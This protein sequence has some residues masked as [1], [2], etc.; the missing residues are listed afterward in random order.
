[1]RLWLAGARNALVAWAA[2]TLFAGVATQLLAAIFEIDAQ[3]GEPAAHWFGHPLYDPWR[4]LHWGV[5]LAPVRPGIAFLCVL[6]ALVF[7]LATF[8]TLALAGLI[9]P[10]ELPCFRLRRGFAAWDNLSQ[11]GLLRAN[12]LALG[13]AR[14]H[15]LAKPEIISAPAGNVALVGAP[16]HTDASLIAAIS[17]WRG[18]LVLI[19]ARGLAFRLP[20]QN[21][22]R[23]APG[24]ADSASYNPIL[25]I[26][27]GAHAWA[28]ALLLARSFLQS[29]DDAIIEAF[30]ILVLDQLLAASPEQRNLAA[31]RR[32]LSERH[33]VLAEI[34][35]AWPL[36][37]CSAP[38]PQCEIARAVQVWRGTPNAAV[39]RLSVIDAALNLCANGAYEQVT[40]AHQFR[41]ADL[42][43]GDGAD[44]CV[45]SLPQGDAASPAPLI[46][47]MLA[48]LV[49]ECAVQPDVDH[50]GRPKQR[51]L[52]LV[53][54][55][56]ALQA[57]EA[58]CTFSLLPAHSARNGCHLLA[59]APAIHGATREAL[60]AIAAIGPQ[61]EATSAHLSKLGGAV[62]CW[63]SVQTQ[64]PI[65]R[66]WAF[67]D[68]E[69][70]RRPIVSPDD[71]H[72][73]DPWAA[74]L[75]L[76]GMG[77]IL[78]RAV[79]ANNAQTGFANGATLDPVAHDWSAPAPARLDVLPPEAAT[80]AAAAP[81]GTKI[82]S[83]LTRRAPP[84][85]Q[86]KTQS[87]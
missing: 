42:V 37:F 65:W 2:M 66:N 13:A 76:K 71:L 62:V 5:E 8:A 19:E 53:V 49:M 36:K 68:W 21:V 52:L 63:R 79:C 59:Q 46:S 15:W 81:I 54:E 24:R 39:D 82:R 61:T 12:G 30:A 86:T 60:D 7:V 74:F 3:F 44:T 27:S 31:I 18:A 16:E 69:R 26:R 51:E 45:I 48:Q 41:F 87:T 50:L 10:V 11:G 64:K 9:P 67:P 38:T 1:M 47:V 58:E 32:R 57:L 29:G 40:D 55:A 33:R 75:F 85:S 43:T 70:L 34:C 17:A 22:I 72:G 23:F 6:L 84:R 78:A 80:P 14:R 83:A 28:D 73:A 35:A 56:E 77:P 4:F 25:A 20:R